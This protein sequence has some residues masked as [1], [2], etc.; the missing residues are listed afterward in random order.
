MGKHQDAI[1]DLKNGEAWSLYL[2]DYIDSQN[3][4]ISWLTFVLRKVKDE[5]WDQPLQDT[6]TKTQEFVK[7]AEQEID[8]PEQSRLR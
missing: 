2:L 3:K 8:A 4:F 5:G 7:L 1:R 6:A